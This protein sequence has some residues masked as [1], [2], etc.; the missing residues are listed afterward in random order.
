MNR[1]RARRAEQLKAKRVAELPAN[2]PWLEEVF[3]YERSIDHEV[4][5]RQSDKLQEN[6]RWRN[7]GAPRARIDHT[8]VEGCWAS[9]DG[10]AT[11][12][13]GVARSVAATAASRFRNAIF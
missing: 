4:Y 6:W 13:A 2:R 9:A 10:T 1:V 5:E 8:D 12:A 3:I 7:W 11:N